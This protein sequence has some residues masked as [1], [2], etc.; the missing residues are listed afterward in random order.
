MAKKYFEFPTILANS[1]S[2]AVAHFETNNQR[3][4]CHVEL[5][6]KYFH[7][8]ELPL[9]YQKYC[10][11]FSIGKI[12]FSD[13]TYLD[14]SMRHYYLEDILKEKII[15]ILNYNTL[16]KEMIKSGNRYYKVQ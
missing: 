2:I 12:E 9:E 10:T 5:A 6:N 8:K 4:I 14:V 3:R 15:P 16:I 7:Q 11:S 13:G 1:F